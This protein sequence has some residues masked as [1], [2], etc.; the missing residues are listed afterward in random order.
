MA[1]IL[2]RRVFFEIAGAGVAGYFVS[3]IDLL[4]QDGSTSRGP[5]TLLNTAKNVI[6]ILLA[7]APSQA[8]TFDLKVGPWTPENF[9]PTTIN[10]IDFP[11][12][13]LP[14]IASQLGALRS[15][16]A[17]CR[18]LLCTLSFRHGHKLLEVPQVLPEKS[19]RTSGLSS[20]SSSNQ[21][22]WPV[23]NCR[24]LFRLTALALL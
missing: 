4:G 2:N 10:G 16:E 20:L 1:R 19:R 22:A 14:G 23:R 24:P 6:F 13:L 5:A 21:S 7:G 18:R 11:E 15:C 8:D 17:V 9:R 3:P 12:G